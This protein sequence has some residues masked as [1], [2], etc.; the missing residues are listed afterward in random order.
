MNECSLHSLAAKL[1]FQPRQR[2]LQQHEFQALFDQPDYKVSNRAFL[3]LA[4]HNQLP[5]ARLGLVV[6]KRKA[7]RAVDRN[8]V[9]R[10]CRE[11][12]RLQQMALANLDILILLRRLPA[13]DNNAI[14]QQL[15][16]LWQG[17]LAKTAQG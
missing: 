10:L 13:G 11:S 3:L 15:T 2:L 1:T 4:R 6:G 7:K 14:R 9:K 17:L 5:H 16:P 12:F 8:Q